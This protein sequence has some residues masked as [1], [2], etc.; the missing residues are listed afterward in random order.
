LATKFA[1]AG[2]TISAGEVLAQLDLSALNIQR[3][4]A[5]ASL[6]SAQASLSKLLQGVTP[7]QL[8]VAQAQVDQANAPMLPLRIV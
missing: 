3:D 1:A 5:A 6:V 2:D 7:S 8:A 4:Q